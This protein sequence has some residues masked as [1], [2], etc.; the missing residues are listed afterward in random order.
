MMTFGEKLK[1][2]RTK[3]GLTQEQVAKCIDVSRPNVTQFEKGIYT[4]SFKTMTKISKLF[5]V[6][7]SEL[8]NNNKNPVRT[9]PIVGFTSC[10]G[11]ATNEYQDNEYAYY[12][13]KYFTTDL[14]CL[15]A[16]GDSMAPEIEDGDEIICDPKAEILDGD[17]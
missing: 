8:F 7:M 17:V 1:E 6:D 5:S 10:G 3:K 4:P 12:N 11:I 14:Y 2:L 9:I 15:K 13:G 16:C